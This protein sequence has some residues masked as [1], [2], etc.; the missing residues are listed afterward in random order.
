VALAVA[1]V[2]GAQGQ[3][4]VLLG[5][6]VKV[7]LV[8]VMLVKLLHLILLAVVAVLAQQDQMLLEQVLEALAVMVRHQALLEVL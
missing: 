4:L 2:H 1:V 3:L 7:M 8:V 6:L 5:L